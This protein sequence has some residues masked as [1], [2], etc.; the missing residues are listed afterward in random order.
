MKQKI[1][2]TII[3]ESI[4]GDLQTDHKE[5]DVVRASYCYLHGELEVKNGYD[6]FSMLKLELSP[7]QIDNRWVSDKLGECVYPVTCMGQE[8]TFFRWWNGRHFSGLVVLNSDTE[9]YED[10]KEKYESKAVC[11]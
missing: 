5:E 2:F 1:K 7:E 4:D 10:A 9:Y 6:I 8:C 11:I 3:P